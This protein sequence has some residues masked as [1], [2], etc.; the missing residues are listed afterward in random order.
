MRLLYPVGQLTPLFFRNTFELG[1]RVLAKVDAAL[2][3]V[4]R[5][6][7][8]YD[9]VPLWV[10]V[11]ILL[12][13]PEEQP[14]P[15]RLWWHE[16]VMIEVPVQEVPVRMARLCFLPDSWEGGDRFTSIYTGN[17]HSGDNPLVVGDPAPIHI[18][19]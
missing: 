8:I 6:S 16:R 7:S 13:Q 11:I 5:E 15:T 1:E 14:R 4:T 9:R 10:A 17:I 12:I 3:R 19:R 2:V 18:E